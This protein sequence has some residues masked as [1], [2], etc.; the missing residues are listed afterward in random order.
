MIEALC[1]ANS[2]FL[3]YS[4][5]HQVV[6]PYSQCNPGQWQLQRVDIPKYRNAKRGT[7]RLSSDWPKKTWD[8]SCGEILEPPNL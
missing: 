1:T 3:G 5:A 6:G 8:Q 2:A 4:R 7:A